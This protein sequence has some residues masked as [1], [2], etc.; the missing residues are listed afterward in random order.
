MDN[1]LKKWFISSTTIVEFKSFPV[2]HSCGLKAI[3]RP[4]VSDGLNDVYKLKCVGLN[5]KLFFKGIVS[6]ISQSLII[7]FISITYNGK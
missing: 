1:H 6:F 4:Q 2:S 5:I 7:G 3:L